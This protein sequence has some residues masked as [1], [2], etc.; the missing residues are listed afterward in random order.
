MCTLRRVLVVD[1]NAG[2]QALLKTALTAEG[3]KVQIAAHG[4]TALK[5][6]E[7]APPCLILLDVRMPVLDGPA[8]VQAYRARPSADAHMVVISAEP[9]AADLARELGVPLV[10]KPFDLDALL[11]LVEER[12]NAHQPAALETGGR[13]DGETESRTALGARADRAG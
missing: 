6:V 9:R 12:V 7:E 1:D 8:F 2:I 13:G 3:Y 4:Q 5:R 11:D 10:R